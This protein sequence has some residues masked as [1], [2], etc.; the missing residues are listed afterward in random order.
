MLSAAGTSRG[1]TRSRPASTCTAGR[2]LAAASWCPAA[3]SPATAAQHDGATAS[4]AA[5]TA[6]RPANRAM[7]APILMAHGRTKSSF[8]RTASSRPKASAAAG[9]GLPVV[10]RV[11]SEAGVASTAVE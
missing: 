11:P 1:S 8:D 5:D 4:H 7:A 6:V 9:W 3:A 2:V 10:Q